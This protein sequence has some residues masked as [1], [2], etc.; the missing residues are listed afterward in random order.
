MARTKS[1]ASAERHTKR[2]LERMQMARCLMACL[3]IIELPSNQCGFVKGTGTI[4]AI[5]TVR[6]VMEKHREKRRELHAAFLDIRKLSTRAPNVRWVLRKHM[7]PE[8][9][10]QWIKVIYHGAR[11]HVHGQ[12]KP[13]RIKTGVHQECS[14]LYSSSQ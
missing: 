10:I 4:D 6:I 12:S 8:V 7:V 11:S 14:F 5:R 13:F 1:K 9:Y 3:Q 2:T